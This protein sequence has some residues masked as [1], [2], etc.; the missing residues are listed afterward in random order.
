MKKGLLFIALTTTI[1]TTSIVVN[2]NVRVAEAYESIEENLSL[3]PITSEEHYTSLSLITTEEEKE[4]S[5]V[6]NPCKYGEI[7]TDIESGNVGDVVTIWATPYSLC[8]LENVTVNGVNLA[9]KEDGSYQFVLVK[10]ENVINA[11]FV[12]DN[13]TIE[14]ITGLVGEVEESGIEEIFTMK[15]LFSLISIVL[16]SFFGIGFLLSLLKS[17]KLKAK[18]SKEIAND[19]EGTLEKKSAEAINNFL[20]NTFA[21]IFDK[22]NSQ[23]MEVDDVCKTLARCFIL[24]QENTPESRL[25]IIDEIT[26]LKKTNEELS[27]QI[28]TA[29]NLEVAKNE[30]VKKQKKQAIEELKKQNEALTK[31]EKSEKENSI[32]GRY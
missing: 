4:A 12:I 16:N 8:K 30:E 19:V 29:I 2:D 20:T 13:E 25:A 15:N 28:R 17:K 32:E 14:F 3:S 22:I 7:T 27:E 1:A 24:S 11:S 6:I 10:G 31:D 5:I 9:V 21:P 18:T 23:M 26:K